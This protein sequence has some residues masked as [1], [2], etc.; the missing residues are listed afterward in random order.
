VVNGKPGDVFSVKPGGSGDVSMTH[1]LWH[2][3]RRV[4]RDLPSPIVLG[5]QMLV[6]SM[7]G[8]ICSYDSDTGKELWKGRLDGNF[9]A[10]PIAYKGLAFFIHEDNGEVS[11]VKPG[12]KLEIVAKNEITTQENGEELFRSAIVPDD[13][14]LLIRSTTMLY[15]IGKRTAKSK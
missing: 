9:S 14:Q 6:V 5:G 1:K 3:P 10:A 11:V 7:Q 12:P 13:G 8:V 15:C 2:T 4:G